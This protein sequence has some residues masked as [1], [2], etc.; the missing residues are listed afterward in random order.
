MADA[1]ERLFTA[2][3][4]TARRYDASDIHLIARLPPAY[5][6]SGEI[7]IASECDP[8]SN[9]TL[10]SLTD[11]L[12]T[13]QQRK[14]LEDDREITYSYFYPTSGRIRISFYHRIG[15]PEMAIRMCNLE[16]KS[17]DDL[18]LPTIV[19]KL[20][21]KT[22]GFII[23]TGPTGMG[24]TTTM[25]YLID[26][27]NATRRGKIIT[28]ED[29]VEFEH[30]HRK[31]IITQIEVG[32]DTHSFAACL[33]HVLRLDP[34]VVCVGE[35]RDLDTIETAL[36]AAETG[37][38]VIATLHTPNAVS[39]ID[40]IIGCFDG[41]RQPHVIMQLASSIEAIIDKRLI[42]SIDKER[43]VL[44]TEVLVAN[45]AIRSIIRESRMHQIYNAIASGRELGMH[46]LE[47]SLA[48][49]YQRGLI[50]LDQALANAVRPDELRGLL[51]S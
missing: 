39:T 36:T 48:S 7:V 50:S 27:I 16:V 23:I 8:L 31:S 40:R 13:T 18:M 32:T 6:V 38:L 22:S 12:L 1:T 47:E 44:A 11:Y 34:D 30:R 29:P 37:H 41:V 20:A 25:N 19:D 17:S 28:I 4:D 45:T 9:E 49:L 46:S 5:R 2:M 3:L 26:L 15:G 42:P 10:L 14:Q 43:R 24:K 33:R 21:N 35:M 51:R